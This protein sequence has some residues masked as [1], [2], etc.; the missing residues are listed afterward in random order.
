MFR[1]PADEN[2]LWCFQ[3]LVF[4]GAD[5]VN[6]TLEHGLLHMCLKPEI[7]EK[8]QGEINKVIGTRQPSYHDRT[9]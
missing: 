4:G 5:T 2:L 8:V 6:S 3:D 9:W 1:C 7:Q